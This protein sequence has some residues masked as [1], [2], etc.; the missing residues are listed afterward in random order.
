MFIYP[1]YI[2]FFLGIWNQKKINIENL[3]KPKT[4]INVVR[5]IDIFSRA[6]FPVSIPALHMAGIVARRLPKAK[7][8]LLFRRIW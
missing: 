6:C 8:Y 5:F 4:P 2:Y 1:I 3:G 7:R